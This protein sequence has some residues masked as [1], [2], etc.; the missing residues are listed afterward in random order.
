MKEQ[1]PKDVEIIN[2]YVGYEFN[3]EELI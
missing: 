3:K 1:L 2:N